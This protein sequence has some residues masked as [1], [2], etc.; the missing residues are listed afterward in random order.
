MRTLITGLAGFT[1]RY[2]AER[3]TSEGYEIHG[4]VHR[5]ADQIERT[6]W[7]VH[8]A[9]LNDFSALSSL[10]SKIR[11]QFV[12]H[13]AAIAHVRHG[14]IS[15]MYRTNVIASRNLLEA[16][17][18]EGGEIRAVLLASSAQV[19]DPRAGG[20]LDEAATLAPMNDYGVSKLASEYIANLYRGR[21]PVTVVRPF[22][23]TGRGQSEEFLIPKIVASARKRAS[24]IELGN[25]DVARDF[26]DVRT[27]VDAYARLLGGARAEGETYNVCSGRAVTLQQVLDAVASITGHAM[28]VHVNPRFVRPNEVQFLCGSAA[29]LESRIGPLNHIPLAETL[30]WM[31]ED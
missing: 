3:L 13:L 25:L 11:P 30:R 14:D 21:L 31:L 9:D 17:A 22:N 24:M 28:Q 5:Q 8:L 6:G 18:C 19:Y 29:K 12:V 1:G 20:T 23:Y 4:V 27:I 16:L 7:Q 2:L 15:E 26:S 10:I